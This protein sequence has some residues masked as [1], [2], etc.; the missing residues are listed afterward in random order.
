MLTNLFVFSASWNMS[1]RGWRTCTVVSDMIGCMWVC[2]DCAISFAAA[3]MA[4]AG[5]TDG[6]VTYLCLKNTV[7]NT[8]FSLVNNP[9]VPPTIVLN[10]CT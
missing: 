10:C 7:S 1:S 9:Q 5:V 8:L 4:S 6:F 2:R 3:M